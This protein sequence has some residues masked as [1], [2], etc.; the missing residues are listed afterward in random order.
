MSEVIEKDISELAAVLSE[1]SGVEQQLREVVEIHLIAD[2][3][4]KVIGEHEGELSDAF[5]FYIDSETLFD[6]K[7]EIV[8]VL[9]EEEGMGD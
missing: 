1:N 3:I 7:R 8:E 2:K 9:R 4:I 5:E 6:I